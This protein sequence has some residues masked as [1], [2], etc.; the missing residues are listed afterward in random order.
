MLNG[1]SNGAAFAAKLYC[2]GETFGG[3]V[4]GVV[5]DD[6]VP[7]EA[8]VDCQPADEVDVALYW[9]GALTEAMPGASCAD[10][11]WVCEGSELLGIDAYA[12]AIGTP[13]L[14][15]PH[16]EHRWHRDAPQ[17]LAWLNDER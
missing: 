10:L 1:F 3:T 2:R 15:S 13:I 4:V 6:P 17:L 8:V 12:A 16:D 5:V 14:A 7:D 11:H 9:T